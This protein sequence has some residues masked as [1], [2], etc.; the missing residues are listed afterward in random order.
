MNDYY[1]IVY[2]TD[3]T[4]VDYTLT[5]IK[6]VFV[7]SKR[8]VRIYVICNAVSN[9]RKERLRISEDVV[10]IDY[11]P[12]E[13]Y[14]KYRHVSSASFIKFDIPNLIKESK[15]L[16]VD[17]DTI[18]VKDITTIF[19]YDISEYVAAVMEDF[20]RTYIW[21][22]KENCDPFYSGTMLLNLD[23]MR[24][25]RIS[26]ELH[27]F[28]REHEN[29]KEWNEQDVLNCVLKGR[30]LH[31]PIRWCCS[32]EKI[33][34]SPRQ[35]YRDV[36]LYN[37][38]YGTNYKVLEDLV[39]DA[40]VFHFHGEKPKVYENPTVY[41][42]VDAVENEFLHLRPP[43]TYI[44]SN[45]CRFED[46]EEFRESLGALEIC[47]D[48]TLVFLNT[49]VMLAKFIDVMPNAHIRTVHRHKRNSGGWWGLDETIRLRDESQ[50]DF[51]IRLLD[52]KGNISTID[53]KLI[54]QVKINNYP[55]GQMPTTGYLVYMNERD[56][57]TPE[58]RL[59]NFYG[60]SDHSTPHFK[61]H[62]WDFEEKALYNVKH[63]FLEPLGFFG[64]M[65]ISC[66]KNNN[67][68]KKDHLIF[69]VEKVISH[70]SVESD[71]FGY[72]APSNNVSIPFAPKIYTRTKIDVLPR[73]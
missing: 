2:I 39:N 63:E 30:V 11:T 69:E 61:P 45:V 29:T 54:S 13:N 53:G 41:T 25:E 18:A 43:K 15:C 55:K 4:Y 6:S 48:D 65:N 5:S 70:E 16:Y 50:K 59:V 62:G 8:P 47:E 42:L 28:K 44:F 52:N 40:A 24:E 9:S 21:P 51:D 72:R 68:A 1:P 23:R 46:K 34:R 49:C 56:S 67:E 26:D 17:G 7:T 60:N 20:G 31:I 14:G 27:S 71:G 3:D 22:S 58:I 73:L 33:E 19:D 57:G 36:K 66:G 38:L 35:E 32:L 12:K 64:N 37:A 10:L